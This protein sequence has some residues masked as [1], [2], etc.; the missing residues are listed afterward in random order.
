MAIIY[1]L[2]ILK[3]M[4]K[5]SV[6]PNGKISVP[7]GI[8]EF[9]ILPFWANFVQCGMWSVELSLYNFVIL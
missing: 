5:V 6:F 4:Q 7:F 3:S 1:Y 2:L 8:K 9:L